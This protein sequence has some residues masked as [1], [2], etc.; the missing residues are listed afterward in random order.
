[1]GLNSD[2]SRENYLI[3]LIF[4]FFI[5]ESETIKSTSKG[6]SEDRPKS[7]NEKAFSK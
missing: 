7:H 5:G 4:S 2:S 6:N 3:H 1:M